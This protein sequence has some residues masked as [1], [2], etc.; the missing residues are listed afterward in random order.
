MSKTELIEN[1]NVIIDNYDTYSLRELHNALYPLIMNIEER[2]PA[3][4]FD[5]F[6]ENYK[7]VKYEMLFG[8][9]ADDEKLVK[10][11]CKNATEAV[12]AYLIAN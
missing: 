5:D 1:I 3:E 4:I 11:D 6:I 12:L 2:V 7:C 8:G 9:D 10:D